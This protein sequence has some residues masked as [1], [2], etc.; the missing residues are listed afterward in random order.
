VDDSGPGLDAA[1]RERLGERFFRLPGSGESGSG[2]GW[3]IARRIAEVHGLRL[4]AEASPLGGLRAVVDGFSA[5]PAAATAV[6]AAP[7]PAS[8]G[9]APAAGSR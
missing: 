3:S 7:G 4:R 2:L 1:A 6:P 9:S 8:A 5:P